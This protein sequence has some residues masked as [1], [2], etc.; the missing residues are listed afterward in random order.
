[1]DLP[2]REPE[3]TP[4]VEPATRV[5]EAVAAVVEAPSARASTPKPRQSSMQS[6][7]PINGHLPPAPGPRPR[8]P[9]CLH[10]P[11]NVSESAESAPSSD[12]KPLPLLLPPEKKKCAQEKLQRRSPK[13][14]AY[15]DYNSTSYSVVIIFLL[16]FLSYKVEYYVPYS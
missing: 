13:R 2:D 15:I 5:A 14:I 10:P 12:A 9:L 6:L 11:S 3:V 1:M 7:D 16:L 8:S 4:N